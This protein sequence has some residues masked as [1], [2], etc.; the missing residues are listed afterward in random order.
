MKKTLTL[1]IIIITISSTF[2]ALANNRLQVVVENRHSRKSA[3]VLLNNHVIARFYGYEPEIGGPEIRAKHFAARL[4]QLAAMGIEPS[5]NRFSSGIFNDKTLVKFEPSVICS[6][7]EAETTINKTNDVILAKEWLGKVR[8]FLGNL[9][10]DSNSVQEDRKLPITGL[11]KTYSPLIP[12]ED[13]IIAHR[14]LPLGTKIRIVNLRN[15]W[16]LV[17][18]VAER[19]VPSK[20]LIAALAPN[21]AE[22][23]GI[24][25]NIPIRVR[26]EKGF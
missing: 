26:L 10:L 12:S 15:K 16:S 20:N 21:T 1:I 25:P 6:I 11:V 9:P 2:L 3:S 18:Q 24:K 19:A 5:D 22:A 14:S 8:W 23:L 17:A 7:T 4:T 13:F